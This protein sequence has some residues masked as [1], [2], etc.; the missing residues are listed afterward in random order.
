MKEAREI[1]EIP[2]RV[3]H[4]VSI[5]AFSLSPSLSLN[6]PRARGFKAGAR[7]YF[8]GNVH[9]YEGK[10]A[11]EALNLRV[12]LALFILLPH[13]RLRTRRLFPSAGARRGHN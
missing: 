10:L 6:E 2:D 13:Y 4:E 9:E 11:G 1:S 3:T 7:V 8:H 5:R 12:R